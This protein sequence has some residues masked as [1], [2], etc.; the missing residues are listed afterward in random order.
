MPESD[1]LLTFLQSLFSFKQDYILCLLVCEILYA[2]PNRLRKIP[3]IR[4]G[5]LSVPAGIL[6]Y[7][8]MGLYMPMIPA[9]SLSVALTALVV[10]LFSI[11]LQ[12]AVL[13]ISA[14]R[15]LFLCTAA[16][17]TQNLALNIFEVAVFLLGAEGWPRMLLKLGLTGL[18]YAVCYFLFAKK[19]Q[20]RELYLNK[21]E[22]ILLLLT[23]VFITNFMFSFVSH[24]YSDLPLL[25]VPLAI[26][27]LLALRVQF[28]VFHDSSLNREKEVLEQILIREQKQHQ[29]RQ[30][31][32]DMINIKSHDLKKQISL[33]RQ[34]LGAEADELIREVES[35]VGAYNSLVNT[36]NKNLDLIISEE[37]LLCEKHRIPFDVMAD[38]AALDFIRPVDLYS[39]IGNALRNAVENSVKEDEK[40][41]SICLDIHP[42]NGYVCIEVTNYCTQEIRFSN[43]LPET[44]KDDAKFHGFG[45]KSMEYVVKK[46]G[47]NMVIQHQNDTFLVKVILP[48]SREET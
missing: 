44:S 13:D 28:G 8:A 7:L 2:V 22:L 27:C 15:A 37:K 16:Y 41:R 45:V 24:Q 6:L 18:V 31:T 39:L 30:E 20:N 1:V 40:H 14:W 10:F 19:C 34:S 29:L 35:V 23:T 17:A 26:C 38:G 43:G 33:L 47:G 25:K 3:G 21:L 4:P 48:L 12:W 32:I 11:L 5:W 36:G 42:V 46:Y 9:G